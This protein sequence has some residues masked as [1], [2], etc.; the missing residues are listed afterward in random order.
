MSIAQD[1]WSLSTIWRRSK[2]ISA[3]RLWLLT[4]PP[5]TS[6]AKVADQFLFKATD[7]PASLHV[8]GQLVFPNEE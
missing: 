3:L 2:S 4:D 5:S 7:R 1:N 6:A 8:L